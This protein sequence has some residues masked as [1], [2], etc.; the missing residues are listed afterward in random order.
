MIKKKEMIKEATN[1]GVVRLINRNIHL[2]RYLCPHLGTVVALRKS[3]DRSCW[4][5]IDHSY[6]MEA[7]RSC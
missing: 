3:G 7:D 2:I 1:E 4:T 6:P 5:G